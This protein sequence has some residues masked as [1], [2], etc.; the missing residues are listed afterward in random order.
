MQAISEIPSTEPRLGFLDVP[1]SH[2]TAQDYIMAGAIA[3]LRAGIDL[4]YLAEAPPSPPLGT[5]TN[6]LR[7]GVIK[8]VVG[9]LSNL[10]SDPQ[11]PPSSSDN[12]TIALAQLH[13]IAIAD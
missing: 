6:R 12:R 2:N 10:S 7:R 13:G 1:A 9:Y 11:P 8:R 4:S 5:S 3:L